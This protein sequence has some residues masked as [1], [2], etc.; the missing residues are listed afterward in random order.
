M[1]GDSFVAQQAAAP[2]GS[3]LRW[4]HVHPQYLMDD[5]ILTLLQ[6]AQN[7]REGMLPEAGGVADQAAWTVSAVHTILTTWGRMR[8]ALEAKHRKD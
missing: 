4:L 5:E 6:L 2:T 1:R 3:G 8:A 7:W